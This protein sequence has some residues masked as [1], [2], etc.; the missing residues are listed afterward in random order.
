MNATRVLITGIA[1]LLTFTTG[2][3][4]SRSTKAKPLAVST[5]Q[6]V[7][8]RRYDRAV[9]QPF[10]FPGRT[11]DQPNAG[12][13]FANNLERRLRTD[14]GPLFQE[15]RQG[16]PTGASDELVIGGRIT[17]F[18]PGSRAGRLFIPWGPRAELKGDLVLKDARN[19]DQILVAP[20]DKLWGWAGG[21]GAM[22]G[23]EDMIDETAA[24]A[25]NTIARARGWDPSQT[26]P[27]N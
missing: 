27:R 19:G 16:Q 10:E 4:S 22:K 18:R 11:A 24:A 14:F 8:L 9:I 21:V 3:A 12:Q 5:G 15:V 13:I 6:G 23:I 20:F 1:V 17:E 26:T 7:D 25:A 2:C